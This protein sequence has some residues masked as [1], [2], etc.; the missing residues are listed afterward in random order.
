[1][2]H[3]A[4]AQ[5]ARSLIVA[6]N[7]AFVRGDRAELDR[8]FAEIDEQLDLMVAAMPIPRRLV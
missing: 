5:A 4:H 6:A 8:L 7:R 2:S 3:R 1:M